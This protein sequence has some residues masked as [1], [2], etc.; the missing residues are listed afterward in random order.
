M[1]YT[2]Q[3]GANH[4]MICGGLEKK[5][6]AGNGKYFASPLK[7]IREQTVLTEK[8]DDSYNNDSSR[9]HLKYDDKVDR[10]YSTYDL[11]SLIYNRESYL[12]GKIDSCKDVD[13]FSFSYGEKRFY[14]RMGIAAEVT[15][16]LEMLSPDCECELTIYDAKGNQVGIAKDKGNGVKEVTLPNWDGITTNYT[17]RVEGNEA[18]GQAYRIKVKETKTKNAENDST[19]HGQ[20][21][22]EA[23]NQA[24]YDVIQYKYE[25]YYKEQLDKLH[26][27]QF[28]SL[29][30]NEKYQGK[31]TVEELLEKYAAG[32]TLTKQELTYLKIFAGMTD[33]EAAEAKHFIQ[34]DFSEEIKQKAE[35]E[36]I[37]WPEGSW[38][39][40]VDI[41]GKLSVKGDILERDREKIERM[42]EENFKDRLWGKYWQTQ[43]KNVPYE[44]YGLINRYYDVE[45]FIGR[46]TNGEYSWKDITVDSN[47]KIGGLPA[48]L[49]SILNSYG[50]NARY[51]DLSDSIYLL[52]SYKNTH[53]LNDIFKYKAEYVWD[54]SALQ[55]VDAAGRKKNSARQN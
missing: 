37:D 24:E 18:Q 45:G 50:A 44:Q 25:Q 48:N 20:E 31:L 12:E 13:Y 41:K 55:V 23:K 35:Q 5:Y 2:K 14:S 4:E 9:Q 26:R 6:Y 33:F 29:P 8:E 46:A 30:E 40:E 36:N 39:I 1:F 22:R 28:Q 51:E 15:F 53:N 52:D 32:E 7:D 34:T 17:V 16:Q 3:I 19:K 11:A 47:G 10:Y 27:E 21:L 54:G 43:M 38:G 42:L 49:C